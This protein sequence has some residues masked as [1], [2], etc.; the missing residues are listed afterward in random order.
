MEWFIGIAVILGILIAI[1][2]ESAKNAARKSYQDSLALLKND[3]A[4]ADLRQRTLELGRVYSNLM[5]D[6][7]GNTVFDEVALMND[8]NAA[9]AA[10][11]QFTQKTATPQAIGDVEERLLK[12]QTLMTKGLIDQTDF[13]R[14]KK[15]IMEQV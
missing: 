13:E 9:C 4:N 10:A 14:R 5:R 6:K 3:P 7:K 2:K 12:L 11:H 15:E 8:I 1:G